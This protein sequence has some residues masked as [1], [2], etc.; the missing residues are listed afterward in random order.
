MSS[1]REN[2]D[3][4]TEVSETERYSQT[5]AYEGWILKQPDS[6]GYPLP[7]TELVDGVNATLKCL[8]E[9]TWSKQQNKKSRKR[10]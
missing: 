8:F 9:I 6:I 7:C 10:S 3:R 5:V 4:S 2:K 1:R